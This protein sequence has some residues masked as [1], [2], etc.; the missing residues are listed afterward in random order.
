MEGSTDS[1]SSAGLSDAKVKLLEVANRILLVPPVGSFL[2][3]AEPT[4]ESTFDL[5]QESVVR[6]RE[7]EPMVVVHS[8]G[9]L[10]RQGTGK[11]LRRYL[12]RESGR[13]PGNREV[14]PS[15]L[16]GSRLQPQTVRL[17]SDRRLFPW[18][19]IDALECLAT[20]STRG[21]LSDWAHRCILMRLCLS[22]REAIL[23]PSWMLSLV[24]ELGDVGYARVNEARISRWVILLGVLASCRKVGEARPNQ[25]ELERARHVKDSVPP[26]V[27]LI[28]YTVTF[29]STNTLRIYLT[30]F[31]V[32]GHGHMPCR[33]RAVIGGSLKVSKRHRRI[34]GDI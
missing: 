15:S 29:C 31:C 7:A 17:A 12:A 23:G 21:S 28:S 14:L 10:L 1:P 13:D 34:F 19:I 4:F 33:R 32:T 30:G 9:F 3:R 16:S 18:F 22:R 20:L 8:A 24:R 2:F 27:L 11:C 25:V 6:S 26:L 5:L